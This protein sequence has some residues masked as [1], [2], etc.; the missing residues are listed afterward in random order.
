[1]IAR[2]NRYFPQ[3][4]IARRNPTYVSRCRQNQEQLL[5]R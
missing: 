2:K 1:M 3:R 4:F 5:M